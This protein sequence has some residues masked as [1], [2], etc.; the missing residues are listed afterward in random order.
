MVFYLTHLFR[1]LIIDNIQ[2]HD[3]TEKGANPSS[4]LSYRDRSVCRYLTYL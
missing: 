1:D 4:F 3:V 2:L